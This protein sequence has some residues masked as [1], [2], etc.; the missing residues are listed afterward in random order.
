[1]GPNPSELALSGPAQPYRADPQD[2]GQGQGGAPKPTCLQEACCQLRQQGG[3]QYVRPVVAAAAAAAAAAVL[4]AVKLPFEPLPVAAACV[5]FWAT[6][7]RLA[8]SLCVVAHVIEPCA[9]TNAPWLR[10]W[11]GLTQRLAAQSK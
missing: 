1:V 11:A 8:L 4:F 6:V 3:K 10:C 9:D 5:W 7:R 2:L